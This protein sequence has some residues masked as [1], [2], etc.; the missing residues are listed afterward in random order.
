METGSS[1]G[2]IG[3]Y[4]TG[5]LFSVLL[6]LGAYMA[7]T[8]PLLP[9]ELIIVTILLFGGLQLVVQL[10]YFLHLDRESS[11]RWNLTVFAFSCIIVTIL[12][13]GSIWIMN[14]LNHQLMPE[15]SIVKDEGIKR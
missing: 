9:R 13:G 4:A 8:H 10:V 3:S 15:Q 11:P 14:H 7:V 5:F 12:M 2:S 1:H 6:T